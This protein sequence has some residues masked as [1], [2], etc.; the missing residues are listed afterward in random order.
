MELSKKFEIELSN[1][2]QPINTYKKAL[3]VT[4][5]IILEMGNI[6]ILTSQNSHLINEY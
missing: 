5:E 1:L 3:S 2:N 4:K 6:S